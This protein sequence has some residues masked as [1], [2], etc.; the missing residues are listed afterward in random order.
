MRITNK[1]MSNNTLA[2]LNKNKLN[3]DKLNN[4]M[5]SEKKITRPSD[6][7]IIAIRALR[8]R[9]N[10]S[11]VTQYYDKNVKDA[12]AWLEATQGAV[13]STKS[14]VTD[15]KAEITSAANATNN[16]E[17]RK[18]ILEN[19]RAL[20]DQIYDNA[21]A[22][23]A[24]RTLFTGYRTGT[25]LTFDTNTTAVY[26]DITEGFNA[27]DLKQLTYVS[28]K[29]DV[30]ADIADFATSTKTEL[31]VE[32]QNVT[33]YRLAYDDLDLGQTKSLTYRT[34]LEPTSS[35]S[36]SGVVTVS[37]GSVATYTL[38]KDA[39]G[40]LTITAP[41][42]INLLKNSDGTYTIEGGH[43]VTPTADTFINLTS[44]GKVING[45]EEHTVA[46]TT[47]SIAGGGTAMDAAY[48]PGANEAYLIP[49]TGEL[50]IGETLAA[51]LS[52]L[53]DIKGVD[54]MEISYNK[55]DWNE[56]DLRPEHYFACEDT[57]AGIVYESSN[58]DI[59]YDVSANQ[60]MRI[61][62]YASDLFVHDI[63]RD[64]DEMIGALEDV[65][66]AKEKVTML[67]E[68]MQDT[69]LS[70]AEIEKL[71][72]ILTAANKEL[73]LAT[74]KMQKLF[75]KGQTSFDGY[76]KQTTLAGT[77]VGSRLSRLELVSNRLLDL[78][79]TVRDLADENENVDIINIGTEVKSASLVYEAA[80]M[81]TGQISQQ[82]LLNYI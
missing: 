36:A 73:T 3:L 69:T 58:Q 32:G 70:D 75:E 76:V 23:Y 31:S 17:N 56:G 11:E 50:V 40:E 78:K 77:E 81:A 65:D 21:N 42:G 82:S 26:K 7:P 39:S 68:K 37:V 64:V 4:Q 41:A 48:N 13:E 29:L 79:T 10:L 55:S 38:A 19:L 5:A 61:N 57:T 8:L 22:D 2:N 35:V 74:D 15:I 47:K 63:G 59:C 53:K 60:S 9:G 14:I 30:S 16:V 44:S 80:L 67:E 12:K 54:T 34:D 28:G 33:R 51:T 49:E 43:T 24:G 6:D 71:D 1:M 25:K 20:R 62:T 46:L 18:A 52:A 27:S 72:Q 45:Y 66:A